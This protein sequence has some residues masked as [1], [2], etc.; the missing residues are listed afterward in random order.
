GKPRCPKCGLHFKDLN[1]HVVRIHKT[2]LKRQVAQNIQDQDVQVQTRQ[3]RRN[4][5]LYN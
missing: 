4:E 2:T 3:D 1:R 5:R